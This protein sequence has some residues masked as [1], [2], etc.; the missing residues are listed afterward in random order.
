MSSEIMVVT[1]NFLQG[2]VPLL[3]LIAYIPQWQKLVKTQSSEDISLKSW[4]IWTVPTFFAAF[5]SIVQYQV[6]GNGGAL[7]FSAVL[8]L[9][10]SLITVYLIFVYRGKT[11][12]SSNIC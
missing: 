2:C 12:I 8:G 10:F 11:N 4:M 5:Y 3:S 1:A 7:V 9:L 6:T